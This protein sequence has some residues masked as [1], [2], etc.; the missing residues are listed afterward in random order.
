MN[1][2]IRDMPQVKAKDAIFVH[3]SNDHLSAIIKCSLT[4]VLC[5]IW[6]SV[7][8]VANACA[9]GARRLPVSMPNRTRVSSVPLETLDEVVVIQILIGW[10]FFFKLFLKLFSSA[11]P[12]TYS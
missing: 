1:P 8:C 12:S 6:M 9:I 3:S 4:C 7:S 5:D 11:V 10:F 2:G